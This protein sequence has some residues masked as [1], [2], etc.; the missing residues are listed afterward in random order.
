MAKEA[1]N[2]LAKLRNMKKRS[3]EPLI[4]S[5]A[6]SVGTYQHALAE[7]G[8]VYSRSH[9]ADVHK[10]QESAQETT[11]NLRAEFDAAVQ[12]L[13]Q[14]AT[15]PRHP[16]TEQTKA[17]LRYMLDRHATVE[18]CCQ[19]ILATGRQDGFESLRE[20][21]GMIVF[22]DP[23]VYKDMEGVPTSL[24]TPAK[25]LERQEEVILPHEQQVMPPEQLA[26][27]QEL[28]EVKTMR[29]YMERNLDNVDK[30]LQDS[31]GNGHAQRPDLVEWYTLEP[32]PESKT[33]DY[34]AYF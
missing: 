19:W 22:S 20:V 14:R 1:S 28:E 32:Q 16:A 6:D 4:S 24:R 7:L 25:W 15:R 8:P 5:F 34:V 11:R 3:I 33:S 21:L 30:W 2:E 10:A 26:A 13:Q 29:A 23:N 12:T 31:L 18:A 17:D 9:A 27:L